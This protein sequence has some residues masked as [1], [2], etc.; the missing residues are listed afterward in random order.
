M[1]VPDIRLPKDRNAL[2]PELARLRA[3]NRDLSAEI[4]RIGILLGTA[5]KS[6]WLS[7]GKRVG[8]D[9]SQQ[10]DRIVSLIAEIERCSPRADDEA[11]S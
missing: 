5:R 9:V 7:L 11:R 3:A 10:I 1:A 2:D 6:R 8:A 4:H